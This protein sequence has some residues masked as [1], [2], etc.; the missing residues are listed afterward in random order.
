[1]VFARWHK[2]SEEL[3]AK[4]LTGI[5]KKYGLKWQKTQVEKIKTRLTYKNLSENSEEDKKCLIDDKNTASGSLSPSFKKKYP[6]VQEKLVNVKSK[7]AK[8]T[9]T[10]KNTAS[11]ISSDIKEELPH[12]KDKAS[13][14]KR[15]L[16]QKKIATEEAEL[17]DPED[18]KPSVFDE[19]VSTLKRNMSQKGK[20]IKDASS[21]WN[22]TLTKNVLE[23]KQAIKEATADWKEK[24]L[25]IVQRKKPEK[26]P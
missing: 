21:E 24:S 18:K 11:L 3:T 25:A 6:Q 16:S 26:G 2:K 14:L 13:S 15:N 10:A 5:D 20:A 9:E 17:G 23:K 22:S 19:K 12:I 1:M 4:K 7:L 8:K